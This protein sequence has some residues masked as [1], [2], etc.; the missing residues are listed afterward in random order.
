MYF[1]KSSKGAV[2]SLMS[3]TWLIVETFIIRVRVEDKV[4]EWPIRMYYVHTLHSVASWSMNL[5]GAIYL[6]IYLMIQA[7]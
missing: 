1:S 3:G 2:T 4:S 7:I 6:I 5:H